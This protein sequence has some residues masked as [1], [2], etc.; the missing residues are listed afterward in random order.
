MP[1][2]N[3][4]V[5]LQLKEYSEMCMYR[6]GCRIREDLETNSKEI[7]DVVL[8]SENEFKSEFSKN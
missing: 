5:N 8:K 2:I 4:S 1:Q 3:H 7:K 6:E